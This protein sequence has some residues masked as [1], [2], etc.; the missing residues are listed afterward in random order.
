ME[1]RHTRAEL[2]A[3]DYGDLYEL[4]FRCTGGEVPADVDWFGEGSVPL[5]ADGSF[6]EPDADEIE[7]ARQRLIERLLFAELDVAIGRAESGIEVRRATGFDPEE[8]EGRSPP[9]T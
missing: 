3:L 2:E 9:D 4:L 8:P 6:Y 7:R 5:R 1:E